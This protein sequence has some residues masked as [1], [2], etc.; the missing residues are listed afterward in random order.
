MLKFG[1]PVPPDT[2]GI[3]FKNRQIS[4][5][6]QCHNLL[7]PSQAAVQ[8]FKESLQYSIDETCPINTVYEQ[9]DYEILSR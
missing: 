2:L 8:F 3:G 5:Q 1:N 9:F 4:G 7:L 6:I